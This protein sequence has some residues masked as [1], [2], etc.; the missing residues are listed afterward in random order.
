MGSALVREGLREV[1]QFARKLGLALS[2]CHLFARLLNNQEVLWR[3]GGWPERSAHFDPGGTSPARRTRSSSACSEAGAQLA[4]PPAGRC[5]SR[6]SSTPTSA[7]VIRGRPASRPATAS[8]VRCRAATPLRGWR[9]GAVAKTAASTSPSDTRNRTVLTSLPAVNRGTP[10]GITALTAVVTSGQAVCGR[11]R[12]TTGIQLSISA[13]RRASRVACREAPSLPS[14]TGSLVRSPGL[15][16][17]PAPG[18][19]L[20]P[21][22]CARGSGCA[23]TPPL[24]PASAARE[25]RWGLR[26]RSD[27]PAT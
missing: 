17:C 23:R 16:P 8:H 25:R 19:P 21:P 3:A 18:P 27:P 7:S 13:V 11:R 24:R 9:R 12:R 26:Y 22:S 14:T 6:T 1:L 2:G 20:R 15:P 10:I 5:P 4:P